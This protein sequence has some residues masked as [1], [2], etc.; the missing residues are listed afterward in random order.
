MNQEPGTVLFLLVIIAT[1]ALFV[2]APPGGLTPRTA[3]E[4]QEQ[5]PS[6]SITQAQRIIDHKIWLGMTDSM[7]VLSWGRPNDINRSVYSWGTHEQWVYD[8]GRYSSTWYLY[9]EEGILTS[10][11]ES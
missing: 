6:L 2:L 8:G 10:W 7:A 1:V 11:Q 3:T 5:H 4:L 9:F